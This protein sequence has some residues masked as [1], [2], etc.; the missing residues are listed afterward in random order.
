MNYPLEAIKTIKYYNKKFN[1]YPEDKIIF[2]SV[3]QKVMAITND[4]SNQ[5]ILEANDRKFIENFIIKMEIPLI[6]EN[7]KER[8]DIEY[9]DV[10]SLSLLSDN[11]ILNYL[12][13]I[14]STITFAQNDDLLCLKYNIIIWNTGF[15]KLARLCR[16]KIFD[17]KTEKIV[18]YPFDKFFNIN[19]VPENDEKLITEMFKNSTYQFIGDKKDGSTIIIS[20]YKGEPLITTN[21]SFDSEQI[22]MA[23]EILTK[24]HQKFLDDLDYGYTY[25]FE[26]IHP[27]N[28]IIIDYGD[29]KA[30]YLLAIRDLSTLKLLD[31]KS[32]K[33]FAEKYNFKMPKQFNFDNIKDIV[34]IATTSTEKDREGWV[35]RLGLPSGD[36]HMLK[37]KLDEYFKMHR[38]KEEVR[39]P[40][41][42]RLLVEHTLDDFMSVLD[43]D[44][45][46]KVREKLNEINYTQSCILDETISLTNEYFVK[47]NLN[48]ETIANDKQKLIDFVRDVQKNEPLFS[49]FIICYA[50][51]PERLN[52]K[53]NY[54]TVKKMK[55]FFNRYLTDN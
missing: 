38:L 45:K 53:I 19:E 3:I 46:L 49:F 33:S 42:Y 16:G 34:E 54:I 28:R 35:L 2:Y 55:I 24:T 41:V 32:I 51:S 29:E 8:Y 11:Q 9:K 50:K 12:M 47:H 7:I 10:S 31:I 40:L 4:T 13:Y 48:H 6:I 25:I 26:L 39:L 43:E 5:I 15:H 14:F 18:S 52:H 37:I 1:I 27:Q 30:L 21:G 17:I 20:K 22:P 36:E 23:K 44:G